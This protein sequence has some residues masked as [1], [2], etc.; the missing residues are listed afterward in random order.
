MLRVCT[1]IKIGWNVTLPRSNLTPYVSVYHCR[2]FKETGEGGRGRRSSASFLVTRLSW[3]C[4]GPHVSNPECV[5]F[6]FCL[7]SGSS[8]RVTL[9]SSPQYVSWLYWT[10]L[11]LCCSDVRGFGLSQSGS[12]AMAGTQVV[13]VRLA[14]CLVEYSEAILSPRLSLNIC[15]Q[16]KFKCWSLHSHN[17]RLLS[18]H[19]SYSLDKLFFCGLWGH[20]E[21]ETFILY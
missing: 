20:W 9:L 1:W 2:R 19:C 21:Q 18:H 11:D 13:L 7:T 17:L 6:F 16:I 3:A 5:C 8:P 10:G 4:P 14:V 12:E 15:M